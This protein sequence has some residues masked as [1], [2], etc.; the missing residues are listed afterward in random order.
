MIWTVSA[1][2][3][4][5]QGNAGSSTHWARPGIEPSTSWLLVRFVSTAWQWEFLELCWS[6]GDIQL[7]I[8]FSCEGESGLFLQQILGL[9]PQWNPGD[10]LPLYI[11]L[12]F[13]LEWGSWFIFL[14]SSPASSFCISENPLFLDGLP[15]AFRGMVVCLEQ[16]SVSSTASTRLWQLMSNPREVLLCSALLSC[17]VFSRCF[18]ALHF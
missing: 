5:T 6:F 8:S 11:I 14:L 15:R 3:T 4:T 16:T 13:F 7:N 2:Y 18:F 1:T 17:Q 12:V 10:S 9:D